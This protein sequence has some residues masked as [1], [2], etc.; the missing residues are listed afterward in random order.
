M[1]QEIISTAK[2]WIGEYSG[3][4]PH[5]IAEVKDASQFYFTRPD[6][7]MK[8]SGWTEIGE[9]TITV[10]LTVDQEQMVANKVESLRAQVSKIR[11]EAE[12]EAGRLEDQIQK[13]LAI[14]YQPEAA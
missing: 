4:G 6:L 14:T 10:R 9:A 1:S 5:N 2:A 3:I 7:D 12:F 13:L 8:S 11:A